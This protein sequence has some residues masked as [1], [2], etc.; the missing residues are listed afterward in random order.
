MDEEKVKAINEIYQ[1]LSS[2]NDLS[3]LQALIMLDEVKKAVQLGNKVNPLDGQL[4][5]SRFG[6]LTVLHRK[7]AVKS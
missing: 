5:Y 7:E 3:V 1:V 6:Q 4:I 2:C